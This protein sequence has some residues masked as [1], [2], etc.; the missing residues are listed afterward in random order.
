MSKAKV[1]CGSWAWKQEK[2]RELV[3][4][5]T[6][7]SRL[8]KTE[9]DIPKS[10]RHGFKSDVHAVQMTYPIDSQFPPL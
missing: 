6:S 1:S 5:S 3:V 8:W 4:L 2:E 7:V 10:D 9:E